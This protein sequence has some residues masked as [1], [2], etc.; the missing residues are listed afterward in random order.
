[1][2]VRFD[3]FP[4]RE[5]GSNGFTLK[6]IRVHHFDDPTRQPSADRR[7]VIDVAAINAAMVVV[8]H[9][10]H[11]QGEAV[12]LRPALKRSAKSKK[13]IASLRNGL[14]IGELDG[15]DER[16]FRATTQQ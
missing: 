10:G 5:S 3:I 6:N 11:R 4:F 15:D 8:T 1:M 9:A 14:T 16:L 13:L 7:E 2:A 12:R